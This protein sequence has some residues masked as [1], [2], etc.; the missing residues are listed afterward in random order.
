[1]SRDSTLP[2]LPVPASAYLPREANRASDAM[3]SLVWDVGKLVIL[4]FTTPRVI[5]ELLTVLYYVKPRF[6]TVETHR[7][8]LKHCND[9]TSK[10]IWCECV[11]LIVS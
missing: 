7:I 3:S 10:H 4:C 1:V 9:T 2:L 5:D 11:T 8:H 6:V